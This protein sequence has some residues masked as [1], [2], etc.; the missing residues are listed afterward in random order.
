MEDQQDQ[1]RNEAA[2]PFKREEARKR[3]SVPKSLDMASLMIFGAGLVAF[4]VFGSELIAREMV[5]F[6]SLFVRAGT[7]SLETRETSTLI[8]ASFAEALLVL[9]PLALAVALFAVLSSLIQ[10]GP[11]FTTT[12]LKPDWNRVNPLA[13]L[14]RMF[15][16][17]TIVECAK[18]TLKFLVLGGVLYL[19]LVR[20]AP[21]LL[22]SLQMT[23]SGIATTLRTETLDVLT[24]IVAALAVIAVIDLVYSRWEF[25]KRLR[26][27]TREVRD[28]TKRRE[29]DPRIKSRVRELQ[30]EALKRAMS[31]GRLKGADV[32]L[33]NPIHLCVAIRY[34]K[35]RMDAPVVVAKGAGPVAARMQ[36]IARR[37]RVPIVRNKSLARSLFF[38]VGIDAP[39]PHQH[40]DALA[41]IF[42]WVY[43]LRDQRMET[44]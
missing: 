3:G 34:E 33:V 14:K 10:S 4:H 35:N 42:A 40:Y 22:A 38:R 29:G 19:S 9:A 11:V 20:I 21:A 8:A 30:R 15:S 39:V 2:T 1:N 13:G 26:M 18:T 31:T 23:P 27:S 32:L 6:R 36:A 28:E 44:R 24:R 17:R 43:A 25:A 7:V 37:H 16:M 12:P 41:R 5:L